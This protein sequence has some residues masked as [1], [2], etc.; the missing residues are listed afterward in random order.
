MGLSPLTAELLKPLTA[1]PH[2]TVGFVHVGDASWPSGHSTAAAALA[3]SAVL[4]APPVIRA[5]VATVATIFVLAVSGSLLML[6]WH[7]PS[8]VV[9]GWFVAAMWM[10]LAVAALRVA[11]RLRPGRAGNR[12][13]AAA[14]RGLG[15]LPGCA[16]AVRCVGARC[17]GAPGPE[18]P[19]P[20]SALAARLRTNSRSDSRF[21]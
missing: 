20:R 15:A 13:R 10:S 5:A 1:H 17:P 8:D 16:P 21:R 6:A 11:E 4:V 2:D 14:G 3:M 9:A 7:M 18:A 12:V 19:S